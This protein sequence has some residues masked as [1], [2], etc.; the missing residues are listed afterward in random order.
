[1][2]PG[3]R[4]IDLAWLEFQVRAD[5]AFDDPHELAA[6]ARCRMRSRFTAAWQ[7]PDFTEHADRAQAET[8]APG[9]A[10]GKTRASRRRDRPDWQWRKWRGRK[11]AGRG[12]RW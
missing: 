2:R 1:M 4:L 10:I 8:H 12:Q 9:G 6:G 5:A 7:H 11:W 3:D